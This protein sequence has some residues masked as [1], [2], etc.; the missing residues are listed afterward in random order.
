MQD[1][2]ALLGRLS[3]G[4]RIVVIASAIVFGIAAVDVARPERWEYRE[5]WI[6]QRRDQLAQLRELQVIAPQLKLVAS[7][8]ALPEGRRV[9]DAPTT[10]VARERL[11]SM[12]RQ[13]VA[14]SGLT[15]T[16]IETLSESERSDAS[17]SVPMVPSNITATGTIR[18]VASMLKAVESNPEILLITHLLIARDNALPEGRLSFSLSVEAPWRKWP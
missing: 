2:S 12:M 9:L 6:K 8:G 16:M 3:T 7:G 11:D 1:R 14:G 5:R 4:E 13:L 15:L 10:D 17:G 18:Q